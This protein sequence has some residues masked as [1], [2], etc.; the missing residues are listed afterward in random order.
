MT[1]FWDKLIKTFYF[2][3]HLLIQFFLYNIRDNFDNSLC[4]YKYICR[5]I[6]QSAFEAHC[7]CIVKNNKLC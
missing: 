1:C 6:T 3:Y 4:I 5:R 7:K 2:I